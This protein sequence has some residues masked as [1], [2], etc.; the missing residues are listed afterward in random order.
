MTLVSVVREVGGARFLISAEI[1]SH[2]VNFTVA[3][4]INDDDENVVING[5]VRWDGCSNWSFPDDT[6]WPYHFCWR[7]EIE[8]FGQIMLVCFDL[9]YELNPEWRMEV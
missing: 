3:D 6:T 4:L 5:Y 2:V 9:A 7:G 1:E 8:R